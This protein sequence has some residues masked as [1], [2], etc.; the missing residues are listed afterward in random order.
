M[1]RDTLVKWRVTNA[2]ETFFRH[3][4]QLDVL[5]RERLGILREEPV[6]LVMNHTAFFALE[7]YMIGSVILADHPEADFRTLVWKG[8]SEGPASPWFRHLGCETATIANGVRLLRDGHS[9]LIMPEGIDATDVRNRMN[10]FHTGYLRMLREHPVP[11]VPI[12]FH[13]VDQA[14]PWIVA[15]QPVLEK[16]LMHPVNPDW[17]FLL[18][19]RLPIF[20]PAKVVF[21]VGEPIR[22]QPEAL[23]DEAALQATN[24]HIQGVISGLMDEAESHRRECIERSGLNRWFHRLVEAP[25]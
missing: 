20:R 19:P 16:K 3:Y 24:R 11:I 5:G 13:G 17:D 7:C 14:I 18:I 2:L 1:L 21:A 22:L 8:F 12:G 15:H 6:M 4:F 25:V 10:R 23:A 9:V